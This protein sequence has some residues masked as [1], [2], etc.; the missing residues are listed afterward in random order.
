MIGFILIDPS[1]ATGHK[2][3]LKEPQE[4][5]MGAPAIIIITHSAIRAT[6]LVRSLKEF[7]KAAKIAKLFAKHLK[8]EDQARFLAERRIHFAVGTPHRIK[9]LIDLGKTY[10]LRPY[11]L[12]N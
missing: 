6:D 1:G 12:T 9:E 5:A 11:F 3:L 2:K 4:D 10:T 8:V 7:D